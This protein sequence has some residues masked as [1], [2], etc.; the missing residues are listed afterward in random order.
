MTALPRV[1]RIQHQG[2]TVEG[3]VE[4]SQGPTEDGK[5]HYSLNLTNGRLV[6][7]P[8]NENGNHIEEEA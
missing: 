3:D 7:G 2:H 8:H 5:V 1:M 6:C 4:F